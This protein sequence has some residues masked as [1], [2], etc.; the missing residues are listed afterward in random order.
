M[1][2]VEGYRNSGKTYI[3][4]NLSKI[5]SFKYLKVPIFTDKR[6][7][8]PYTYYYSLGRDN[9]LL[10]LQLNNYIIDR[11]FISNTVYSL[12]FNREDKEYIMDNFKFQLEIFL[13]N[14]ENKILFITNIPLEE[15][16]IKSY[17]LKNIDLFTDKR[18]KDLL[19][20]TEIDQKKVE[21]I[22]LFYD[23]ISY[24]QEDRIIKVYND[25]KT[26]FYINQIL[27]RIKWI[28]NCINKKL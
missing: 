21:E 9:T 23:I 22:L 14:P 19:I 12:L 24:I 26:D 2:I 6:I 13:L 27:E 1:I 11:S 20:K 3:A 25:K 28:I 5:L 17:I 4:K 7:D 16:D 18:N 15:K 8:S 10:S